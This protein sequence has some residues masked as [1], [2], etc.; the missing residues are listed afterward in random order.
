MNARKCLKRNIK[1]Q[2]IT[3]NSEKVVLLHQNFFN[4]FKYYPNKQKKINFRIRQQPLF[5][6]RHFLLWPNNFLF[7][8]HAMQNHYCVHFLHYCWLGCFYGSI[9]LL[10]VFSRKNSTSVASSQ[11]WINLS[12]FLIL[13][14]FWN[15]YQKFIRNLCIRIYEVV[16]LSRL[17]NADE[18][19]QCFAMPM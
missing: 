16:N 17:K 1:F 5:L 9:Q 7:T 14:N 15:N 6:D 8:R 19:T 12:A 11:Q 4:G 3:F 10:K 18:L 2:E 13:L